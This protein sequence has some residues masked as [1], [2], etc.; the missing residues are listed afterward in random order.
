MA[1]R[2]TPP[3]IEIDRWFVTAMLP[4]RTT[5]AGFSGN[6]LWKTPRDMFTGNVEDPNGLCGDCATF[7]TNEFDKIFRDRDT[8][9]GYQLGMVL[10]NG[11][12]LNHIAN[13]M[14]PTAKSTRQKFVTVGKATTNLSGD[15]AWKH[16]NKIKSV[17]ARYLITGPEVLGLRVYDLYYK[18]KPTTLGAW[19]KDR[20]GGMNGTVEVGMEYEFA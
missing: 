13:V 10:W 2:P 15:N 16:A 11:T 7:V 18:M 1:K 4:K 9:D 14:M 19:W 8:P 6:R 20:D 12:V 5:V 17:Q 3:L